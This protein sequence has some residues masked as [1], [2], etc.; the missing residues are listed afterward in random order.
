GSNVFLAIGLM[1]WI[2][3]LVLSIIDNIPIALLLAPLGLELGAINA[4]VPLSLLVG[5]NVGGYMIPFG[6]APNMIA[7]GLAAD[8]GKPISF[9]SFTKIALP[10]GT[11]HLVVSMVYLFLVALLFGV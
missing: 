5:T 1:I 10:L 11:L 6:D 8:E 4:V 7:V 9:L 2:L 3:G